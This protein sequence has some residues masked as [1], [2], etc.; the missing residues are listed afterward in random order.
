M[1]KEQI[2]EL[3]TASDNQAAK[4]LAAAEDDVDGL[5]YVSSIDGYEGRWHRAVTIIFSDPADQLWG[6]TFKY[7]LTEN[8]D[9]DWS[10]VEGSVK[11][12]RAEQVTVTQYVTA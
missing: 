12:M 6:F 8:Q 1:N 2:V 3:L 9:D 5:K 4:Q 10:G 7:G 11:A